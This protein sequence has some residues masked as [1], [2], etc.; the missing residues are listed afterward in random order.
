M[1]ENYPFDM[2][3]WLIIIIT[4]LSILMAATGIAVYCYCKYRYSTKKPKIISAAWHR[5]KVNNNKEVNSLL[6]DTSQQSTAPLKVKTTPEKVID[7]III[8]NGFFGI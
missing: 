5:N 7:I 2:P 8:G 1:N 6:P 3:T 4:M